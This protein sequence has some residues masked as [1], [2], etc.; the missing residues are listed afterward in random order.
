MSS[1]GWNLRRIHDLEIPVQEAIAKDSDFH[2][3]LALC[4]RITEHY[5]ETRY[6]IGVR[7]SLHKEAVETDLNAVRALIQLIR[8]KTP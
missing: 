7:S 1:R 4:Q 8:L 6:P 3:F 5:V 2:Q